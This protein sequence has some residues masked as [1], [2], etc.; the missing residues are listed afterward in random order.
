MTRACPGNARPLWVRWNDAHAW[1]ALQRDC[2]LPAVTRTEFLRSAWLLMVA[3]LLVSLAALLRGELLITWLTPW[4]AY[5]VDQVMPGF[6]AFLLATQFDA[7]TQIEIAARSTSA[8]VIDEGLTV[9][10]G[11]AITAGSQ[12]SQTRIPWPIDDPW[13]TDNLRQRLKCRQIPG[14]RRA[15]KTLDSAAAKRKGQDH[16][17][18]CPDRTQPAPHVARA[19]NLV[20]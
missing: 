3:W 19:G 15:Y 10:P 16:E 17:H 7:A 11:A 6:D 9:P 8:F 14:N 13:R 18:T 2:H 4:L 1:A 12:V 5:M 20:R